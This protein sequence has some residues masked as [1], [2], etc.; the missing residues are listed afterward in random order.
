MGAVGAGGGQGSAVRLTDRIGIGVLAD[1]IPADLVREVL[2]ETGTVQ[3]RIRLLPAHVTVYFVLALSLFFDDAYEEVMRKLVQGLAAM[4]VWRS[5]WHVPTASALCQAR[6][7]LG[8]NRFGSCSSGSPRRSRLPA[9][10]G[11]GWPAGG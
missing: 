1:V 2:V 5:D 7:R 9:G 8:E 11:R 10:A 3:R 6:R 4:R